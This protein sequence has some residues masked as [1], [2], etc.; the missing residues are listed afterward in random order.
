MSNNIERVTEKMVWIPAGR[1]L[2]KSSHRTREGEFILYN[3]GPRHLLMSGFFI[4]PYEVTNSEY[5]IFLEASGYQPEEAHNFLRHWQGGY[6]LHLDKHPVT[7]VSREDACAYASW[8]GK[9][10]PNNIEW[11]WAAQ[12]SDGRCW[13]W[14]D[15]FDPNLCNTDQPGTTPV[16]A[17][18][19]NVSPF[20]IY[21]LVGNV[22]EWTDPVISDGWHR[23]CLLRGGSY[24][25][26]KGS[27]WYAEGGAQPVYHHH[28]FLLMAS[29]L[30]RC[31]TIGFRCVSSE[32][33]TVSEE[34]S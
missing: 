28:K 15:Q 33:V 13:P 29:G 5:K 34:Y 21:D 30:D 31:G 24:Y 1:F 27:S 4:D 2:Y 9:R 10:L 19:A 3:E 16:D 26:P 7:W 6:P 23:W 14:G 12:G 22:W 32:G 17:F 20:G 18:P 8:A 11:Q 25:L